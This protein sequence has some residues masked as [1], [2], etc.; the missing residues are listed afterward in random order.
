MD[1]AEI[2]NEYIK[3]GKTSLTVKNKETGK[4]KGIVKDVCNFRD[5][6]V[7]KQ[8]KFTSALKKSG[9]WGN[10]L[11]LMDK[12][13]II[14]NDAYFLDNL[15]LHEHYKNYCSVF[16]EEVKRYEAYLNILN[17][18]EANNISIIPCYII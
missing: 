1:I 4:T 8:I 12:V 16:P 7:N 3:I 9:I 13:F 11:G 17:E 18:A 5:L 2:R 14:D 15:K 6:Q 10:R